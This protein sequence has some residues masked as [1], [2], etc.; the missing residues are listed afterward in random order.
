MSRRFEW[1]LL[2]GFLYAACGSGGSGTPALRLAFAT[3]ALDGPCPEQPTAP[4]PPPA[5]DSV[6]IELFDGQGRAR[7]SGRSG[8]AGDGTVHF[9]GVPEGDG[10]FL[11]VSGFQ[12]DGTGWFGSAGDV[13]IRNGRDTT[14]HVFMGAEEDVSCAVRPL[15]NPRAFG[16]SA[17]LSNGFALAIGGA[18]PDEGS[19]CG[20]GCAAFT[21]VASVDAF[22]SGSGIVFPRAPLNTPRA[23]A[24]ATVLKDGRVLVVGG[25]SRFGVVRGDGMPFA[26][27]PDDLV[28]TFELYYPTKN[29][30]VEGQLPAGMVF[31]SA[32][33]LQDGSVLLAGGGTGLDEAH[34]SNVLYLYRPA[35]GSAG[36]V[37]E[38]AQ[39]MQVA[40]IGHSAVLTPAGKVLLIGGSILPAA[41]LVE[42]V[43]PGDE[44]AVAEK[45]S[46]GLT[47][48]LFFSSASVIP[49]RPD[50]IFLAGGRVFDGQRL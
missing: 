30:W 47:A 2:L 5:I 40:R 38:V 21:A 23:L 3:R 7:Y 31:H 14:V 10:F 49:E 13:S 36:S 9:G 43:T 12:A 19:D 45:P 8:V 1:I 11:F 17:A 29:V 16:A 28:P 46:E 6:E 15:I 42:E 20:T 27:S 32:T 24:S 44:P 50:E 22:D 37:V 34:A 4:S 25:V 26:V 39:T 41:P 18:V 48:N 33:L 35:P